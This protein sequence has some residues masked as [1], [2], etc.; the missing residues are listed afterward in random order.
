MAGKEKPRMYL[1]RSQGRRWPYF[2]R[3]RSY[4]LSYILTLVQSSVAIPQEN[5][6]GVA[7]SHTAGNKPVK[8]APLSAQSPA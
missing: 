4:P 6:A 7:T 3:P 5:K 8:A 1:Q 2:I